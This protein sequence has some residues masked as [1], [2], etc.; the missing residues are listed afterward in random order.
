MHSVNNYLLRSL[1]VS[2]T[3]QGSRDMTISKPD[4]I[5]YLLELRSQQPLEEVQTRTT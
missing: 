4:T 3:L 2:G 1:Y 5:P